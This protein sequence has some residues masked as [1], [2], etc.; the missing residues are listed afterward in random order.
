M[1]DY[2]YNMYSRGSVFFIFDSIVFGVFLSLFPWAIFNYNWPFVLL[3]TII[4]GY[5]FFYYYRRNRTLRY[6][7]TG[8]SSI[9]YG[10]F[11]FC[12]IPINVP[13]PLVGWQQDLS[14]TL[15]V[16][17]FIASFYFHVKEYREVLK[18]TIN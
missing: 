16:L 9:I 1:S 14:I 2:Y 8:I 18:N 4:F 11:C 3:T 5:L 10:F 13:K 17:G 7:S 15:G 6:I 12:I